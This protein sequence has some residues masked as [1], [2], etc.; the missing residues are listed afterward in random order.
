[1]Q[2]GGVNLDNRKVGGG[3]SADDRCVKVAVVVQGDFKT[4]GS[5]YNMVV[6]DDIA[7]LVHNHTRAETYLTLLGLFLLLWLLTLTRLAAEEILEE[8]V[9]KKRVGAVHRALSQL[10][11]GKTLYTDN[12]VYCRL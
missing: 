4:L 3:I 8:R 9:V 7:V 11:S 1:M 5:V 12:A 6:G 2:I 10:R